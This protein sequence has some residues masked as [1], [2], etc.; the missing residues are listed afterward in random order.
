MSKEDQIEHFKIRRIRH[1]NKECPVCYENRELYIFDCADPA[2]CYCLDCYK[3][4][5]KCPSCTIPKNP[6]YASLFQEE[7]V[8][9]ETVPE[10]IRG[11]NL[12]N[13]GNNVTLG[14]NTKIM[15]III[16]ITIIA[17]V[18]LYYFINNKS[19]D[20]ETIRRFILIGYGIVSIIK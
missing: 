20:E 19:L 17:I 9:R 13:H 15:I 12:F 18:L 4:I 6:H 14:T 7:Y 16:L 1:K 5:D 3:Q 10:E 11:T 2:H 8:R